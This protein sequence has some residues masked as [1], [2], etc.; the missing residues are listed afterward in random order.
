M[1]VKYRQIRSVKKNEKS[2]I[3]KVTNDKL[4]KKFI[5]PS[6]QC[7]KIYET[8]ATGTAKTLENNPIKPV[9][10][11]KIIVIGKK[12]IIKIF[13]GKVTKE[14]FPISY[15]INGTTKI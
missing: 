9:R 6:W 8:Y 10:K 14:K 2:G 4:E 1:Y 5:T 15:K 3:V 11:P 12:G 13:A 7:S